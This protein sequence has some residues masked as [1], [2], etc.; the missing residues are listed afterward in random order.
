MTE[1]NLSRSMELFFRKLKTLPFVLFGEKIK[2]KKDKYHNLRI[3]LKQ[4]RIPTSYEMYISN[5]IFYSVVAG[6]VGALFGAFLAYIIVSVFGLPER[7]THLTFSPEQAWMLQYRDTF[8]KILIVVFLTILF[9]GITYMLFLIYP[10]FK[11]GERKQSI[12]KHLPYA[13]TFMYALS[14]GGM[15]VIEILRSLSKCADTYGEVASEMNIILRDM[16][17]FGTD[18]RTALHNISEITPSDKFR[19]LMYN[20]LAVID[21]G[22][23]IPSYFRDKSEQYLNKAKVDQRG[24]LETLGLIAESYVTAFVAGPLFIIILGVMMS[25]M[26]HGSDVM[27]YA[28]I[29]AVV[30]IGSMMFVVMIDIITPGSTG[31]AP[32]LKTEH[33]VGEI[34]IPDTEEK[35]K[36]L[37]FVKSRNLIKMKRMLRDPLKLFKEKPLYS[38]GLT[39][40]I[41]LVYMLVSILHGI[42]EPSFID[43]ID[44][45]I[46]FM[47][48]IMV[49]PLTIFHEYK[50]RRE[51]WIQS[52]FPDFLKKL[53]STNETGMT[54]AESIQLMT[55]ADIGMSNEIKKIWNDINWGVSISEALKRFANRVRTH[56]V[57]RSITLLTHANESS[58]D[59]GEVLS[60]AARDASAEQELKHERKV[61]MFIYVV[62]IYISFLVF[63]GIIYIITTTF[64]EEMVKAGEATAGGKSAVPL[65]LTRE[66][67]GKY[68]RMFFHGALIQGFTSGLIAGTMG[69]GSIL[70]GLKHSII[71]VTIGYLLFKLFVL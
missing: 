49:V 24:F 6:I 8:I 12:D 42:K 20:L 63:I 43:Y 71:M 31:D 25:V 30:P 10:N 52:Q 61:S 18:L 1:Q 51:E 54:L 68:N 65:S 70:S 44:D 11:A 50:K 62:I 5:T 4:A 14:R 60:V 9:G 26:G 46:V 67:L 53:A 55:R 45:K 23:D 38:L 66:T 58:G 64:L 69:E 40:P 36:F 34:N 48:Y 13:V 17:Y 16:D 22:G 33:L 3:A 47:F 56:L 35:T 57:A 27:V 21:S 15:N 19:D 39:A 29:Y 41:A 59:I 37:K 2:A 32:I 7:L 28:I